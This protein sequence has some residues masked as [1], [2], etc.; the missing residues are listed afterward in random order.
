MSTAAPSSSVSVTTS[1]PDPVSRPLKTAR[2]ARRGAGL[3]VHSLARRLGELR[4]RAQ[5]AVE[6]G[7]RDLERIAVAQVVE[8]PGHGLAERRGRRP[9][10]GRR[11]RSGARCGRRVRRCRRPRARGTAPRGSSRS[12]SQAADAG[13]S[14]SSPQNKSGRP[15]THFSKAFASWLS[16][17]VR[18]SIYHRPR[19]TNQ[20]R[21]APPAFAQYAGQSCRYRGGTVEDHVVDYQKRDCG[22]GRVHDL[23]LPRVRLLRRTASAGASAPTI[24]ASA[25]C[26]PSASSARRSPRST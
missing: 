4:G 21:R 8:R 3:D 17:F 18:V 14:H 10:A 2:P 11:R 26:R 16:V 1:G 6:T 25:S 7:R 19:K 13:R 5:R 24:R 20:A 9:P 23:R 15:R 12:S 22:H